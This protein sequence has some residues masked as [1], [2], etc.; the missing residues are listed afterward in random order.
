M[1]IVISS[2]HGKYIRGASGFIDEVDEARRVVN[3]VSHLL[4]ESGVGVVVFH[5]NESSTQGDNLNRI[6]AAH[7]A[8]RRDLDVS[9]HFNAYQTTAGGMGTECLYLTQAVL[10]QNVASAIADVSGL[11][12]RGPKKRT[13][14]AFLNN[15]NEPAIL[16]EICFVDSQADANLYRQSF[17]AICAAIAEAVSGVT[18]SAPEPAPEPP[19]PADKP[20]VVIT[21]TG[22]AIEFTVDPPDSVDVKVIP[23]NASTTN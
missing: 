17:D 8:E 6:V 15:T 4:S 13:D 7:N 3:R 19:P 23:S 22:N 11:N 21:V 2:G 9:V 16:T 18:Q 20:T 5:D 12:D 14:L 10:A 1:N